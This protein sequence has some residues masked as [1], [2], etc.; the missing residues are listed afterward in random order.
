MTDPDKSQRDPAEMAAALLHVLADRLPAMLAYCDADERCQFANR[1]YEKWLG[2]KPEDMIGRH[3]R[4]FLGPLYALNAPYIEAALRG[5]AQEFE[6][7]I[8]DPRAGPS[9]YGQLQY[10]PDIVDGVV[11]GFCVLGVD[12]TRRKRAE[13]ALRE[14]ERQ[15]HTAERLAAMATLAA[16]IGHEINNPLAAVL[17]NL[18]LA[19]ESQSNPDADPTFVREELIA[20]REA[21]KRMSEIVQSMKL[22]ARGDTTK[23]ELV[24]VNSVLEQSVAVATNAIRYRARLLRDL[25]EVG[26]VHA[27]A[28]QLAQVCVNLLLNAAHA[29]PEETAERNQIHLATR[30][31]GNEIS[32]E[33]ADN[34][35][36]IPEPIQRRL[37]EP[38]FTTKDVGS[39]MGLGLSISNG[40]VNAWGGKMSV[41]S[42]VGEGSVF[43]IVLPAA[44][45]EPAP[46]GARPA[47]L[48]PDA[49]PPSLAAQQSRARLRVLV[50]DDQ[51]SVATALQRMLAREHDVVVEND[52]RAA[53]AALSAGG[54][55][56]DVI[57]CDLM[58][59]DVSGPDVYTATVERRPELAKRF[60][61]MTGGAFTERGRQFLDEVRPPV[62]QK[63]FD[64]AKV[65]ELVRAYGERTNAAAG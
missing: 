1:A 10:I 38:F 20:A 29:L 25:H 12:I 24:N 46:A 34:G 63:P 39:G 16:G 60:V 64:L 28:S 48:E 4:E 15:L 30:R 18:E 43:R 45:E 57:I 58:M 37:F 11:R 36:G 9:R 7:E 50:I 14:L 5:E 47:S 55:D 22:L 42:R 2:I 51:A 65:R 26:H 62:L 59:P 8:P 17:A 32:I 31:Q 56:F 33:V 27:N 49:P 53:V 21:A 35:C 52:G 23:R 44:P 41:E 6:R 54:P 3:L 13:E 19:L 40:I 61:F